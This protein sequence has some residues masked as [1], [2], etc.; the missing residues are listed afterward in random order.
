M[1]K[2]TQLNADN[3]QH[4]RIADDYTGMKVFN[5]N[6]FPALMSELPLLQREYPIVILKSGKTGELSLNVI[7]ALN[8]HENLFIRKGKWVADTVPLFVSLH[9]FSLQLSDASTATILLNTSHPAFSQQNGIP[10]F[11]PDGLPSPFTATIQKQLAQA[12]Q[13]QAETH[14]FLAFV[15]QHK[16]LS[17]LSVKYTDTNQVH[18]RRDGMLVPSVEKLHTLDKTIV[19]EA[20]SAGFYKAMVLIE[21]SLGSIQPLIKCE[22]NSAVNCDSDDV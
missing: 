7:T 8:E 22:L 15:R 14:A 1:S 5:E 17:P 18:Q 13:S 10:L 11:T 9:P 6:T 16:L 21:A 12:Y 20:V 2:L 3:H 19:D 4:L